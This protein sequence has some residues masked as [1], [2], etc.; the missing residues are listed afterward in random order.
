MTADEIEDW[1]NGHVG[2][3]QLVRTAVGF[4]NLLVGSLILVKV[5]G[6]LE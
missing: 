3:L 5:M 2:R 6:W 4:V 1:S